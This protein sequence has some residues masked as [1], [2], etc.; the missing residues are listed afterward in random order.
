[1]ACCLLLSEILAEAGQKIVRR[2]LRQGEAVALPAAH[3]GIQARKA[4]WR[5]FGIRDQVE[6]GIAAMA[7]A[8]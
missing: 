8:H 6:G 2:L 4:K 3:L 5:Y 1:M 7:I